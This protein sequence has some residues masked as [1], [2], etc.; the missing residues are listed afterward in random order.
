MGE[1]HLDVIVDRL[2][3]EFRVEAN[4]GHPQVAYKEAISHSARA[5][6]RFVRQTGGH[7]AFGVVEIEVAPRER[8]AGYEFVDATR[9]G[10][11]PKEYIPA[12][13]AGCKQA[14]ETGP[15]GAYP[16]IDVCVTLLDG[17]YHAVDSSEMAFRNAGILGIREA[18]DR[19][20]PMLLEPIMKLEI[21]V[22]ED[23]FGDVLGDINSRRGHVS[24]VE[25][26]GKLQI[27][28]ATVP[29]AESFG[30]ATQ[31]RSLTQG[32]GTYSMEFDHYA[33]VPPDVTERITGS[34]RTPVR[35]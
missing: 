34:R 18:L 20:G 21:S 13:K 30:Y 6:G 23:F 5:E 16:V 26:R 17:Q 33:Q 27:I 7:G 8:G 12:V 28:R 10:S 35:A 31:L 2:Q 19:A 22:P 3:R 11:I 4:V 1:L 29:L 14:L 24:G 32:R 15:L 9:G 25:A